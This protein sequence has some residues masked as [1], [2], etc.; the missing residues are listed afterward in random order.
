MKINRIQKDKTVIYPKAF[1]RK[2][3]AE[4][5][6]FKK[7]TDTKSE[8]KDDCVIEE[9]DCE[10]SLIRL[11]YTEPKYKL[12]GKPARKKIKTSKRLPEK[13]NENSNIYNEVSNNN[14]IMKNVSTEKSSSQYK[15]DS[16]E[17]EKCIIEEVDCK[18]S[19]INIG[20]TETKKEEEREGELEAEKDD[21]LTDQAGLNAEG[22]AADIM[23]G[24]RTS[25]GGAF[26]DIYN[27]LPNY[28][29]NRYL[30]S[31]IIDTIMEYSDDKETTA[32]VANGEPKEIN[33]KADDNTVSDDGVTGKNDRNHINSDRDN[34]LETSSAEEVRKEKETSVNGRKIDNFKSLKEAGEKVLHFSAIHIKN[35]FGFLSLLAL[36][37]LPGFFTEN[38]AYLGFWA[39]L[40]YI[41]YFACVPDEFFKK[42][43][44]KAAGSAFFTGIAISVAAIVLEVLLH[45]ILLLVVGMGVGMVMSVLVFTVKLTIYQ[46]GKDGEKNNQKKN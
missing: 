39:F 8:E 14:I 3:K 16:P 1:Y 43:V 26:M 44:Q 18:L 10:K 30:N 19:L 6:Q 27:N 25:G 36:L 7:K 22:S 15:Y 13:N 45:D 9:I 33:G 35:K 5:N 20:Y 37:G 23:A 41:R 28:D 42:N 32:K 29:I 11:A 34:G 21:E 2:L 17:D 31:V 24:P 40:Y 46:M 4:Q 12:Q 38:R